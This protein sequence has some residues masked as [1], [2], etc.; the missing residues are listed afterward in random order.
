M[1]QA[2][3]ESTEPFVAAEVA[4]QAAA[5]PP[6]GSRYHM[7][8]HGTGGG[9]FLLIL[10]NVLLTLVSFGVYAAW[11]TTAQRKY[12]WQ[13]MEFHGQRLVYH[14]TGRELL[15]G[16][17][18]VIAGY[19]LFL[20]IPALLRLI[21]PTLGNIVQVAL[22]IGLVS[23]IPFAIYWSRAYLLSRTSWRGVRFSME[24][25]AGLFARTFIVGYLLTIVTLG[26][27]APVW[28][29]RL[30]KVSID[31]SRFGTQAFRYDGSDLE[32]WKIS[33]KGM[34]LSVLTLGIYY[35][36]YAAELAR[37]ETEHTHFQGARARLDVSGWELCKL[38]LI[39]AFGT[40]F[41]L[42]LA[43]PWLATYALRF[44]LERLTFE[45]TIDFAAVSQ[46]D[47]RGFAAG[48][49]LADALDVGV[50]I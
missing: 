39:Y 3:V 30:R 21:S 6:A 18:K 50:A 44:F 28:L 16:Y 33:I 2:V 17:V 36:W 49:G 38:T 12:V 27:Y 43:F 25:G 5:P 40:T 11:A 32:A 23:L 1:V 41:T 20:G 4:A 15:L 8:F 42:G 7:A 10:K 37:Y 35:F 19:L 29:N 24:P 9:L 26:L 31:R 48:D 47:A 34:L 13:N 46:T 22:A 14:G 45:G